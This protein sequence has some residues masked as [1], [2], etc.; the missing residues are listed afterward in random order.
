MDGGIDASNSNCWSS[1][2]HSLKTCS[3]CA[4]SRATYCGTGAACFQAVLFHVLTSLNLYSVCLALPCIR[5]LVQG[6]WPLLERL[7]VAHTDLSGERMAALQQ[8]KW[9]KLEWLDSSYCCLNSASIAH[10][11]AAPWKQLQSLSTDVCVQA[12]ILNSWKQLLCITVAQHPG[13][14]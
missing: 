14:V 13:L 8:S 5:L 7:F 6:N 3:T 12:N 1:V 10:L 11:M 2:Q 4:T 9:P